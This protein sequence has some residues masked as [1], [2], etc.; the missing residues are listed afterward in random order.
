MTASSGVGKS[1]NFAAVAKKSTVFIPGAQKI[2]TSSDF[3]PPAPS[4]LSNQIAPTRAVEVLMTLPPRSTNSPSLAGR[5]GSRAFD[6]ETKTAPI[7][8]TPPPPTTSSHSPIVELP[9]PDEWRSTSRQRAMLSTSNSPYFDANITP[10][11]PLQSTASVV[12]AAATR[13][14]GFSSSAEPSTDPDFE[15]TGT[16]EML[17]KERAAFR[18]EPTHESAPASNPKK[19]VSFQEEP[20]IL[21]VPENMEEPRGLDNPDEW[22]HQDDGGEGLQITPFVTRRDEEVARPLVHPPEV[23]RA[24]WDSVRA[25]GPIQEIK[26]HLHDTQ[27]IM[28]YRLEETNDLIWNQIEK[29]RS[30]LA[31]PPL[32]KNPAP[33]EAPHGYT[34]ALY[35]QFCFY[36]D[37]MRSFNQAVLDLRLKVLDEDARRISRLET[38]C[39]QLLSTLNQTIQ[40]KAAPT[41]PQIEPLQQSSNSVIQQPQT[42]RTKKIEY[43]VVLFNNPVSPEFQRFSA[44]LT[45]FHHTLMPQCLNKI[46]NFL[47]TQ[48]QELVAFG[49]ENRQKLVPAGQNREEYLRARQAEY[50]DKLNSFLGGVDEVQGDVTDGA[51]K[52]AIE[53]AFSAT[54]VE[55]QDHSTALST[56]A[57]WQQPWQPEYS[58]QQF[59]PAAAGGFPQPWQQFS[60]NPPQSFQAPGATWGLPLTHLKTPAGERGGRGGR[61]RGF[62]RGY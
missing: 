7:S 61:G 26:Q 12:Q 42:S 62:G 2:V 55:P 49:K 8:F 47:Q 23:V 50:L 30:A 54:I 51:M 56:A 6:S 36:L 19:S 52:A 38:L 39:E 48:A 57:S 15:L 44:H 4:N 33:G 40:G 21:I 5:Q 46:L 53:L 22:M 14:A 41:F 1:F 28:V 29:L 37:V 32:R 45:H 17:L 3:P 31:K 43:P 18:R 59:P 34:Q 35:D 10:P 20:S 24:I 58:S 11:T 13:A 9:I 27:L 60:N 25:C 16:H